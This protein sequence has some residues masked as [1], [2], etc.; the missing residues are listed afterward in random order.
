MNNYATDKGLDDWDDP[1]LHPCSLEKTFTD[2]KHKVGTLMK[3][4]AKFLAFDP[5]HIYRLYTISVT[6]LVELRH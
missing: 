2:S 3:A 4:Q 6:V 1:S 5:K